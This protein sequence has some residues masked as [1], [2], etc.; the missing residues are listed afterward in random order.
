M[1]LAANAQCPTGSVTFTSQADVNNFIA[2]YPECTEIDGDVIIDGATITSLS[3]LINITSITGAV[4]IREVSGLQSLGG[5]DNLETVGTDFILR[6]VED[7][8]DISALS[9]LVSVGGELT[10]RSCPELEDLD[11]LESLTTVGLG[12]IVRDC[13]SLTG[14]EGLT[15]VTYVGEI[16][17]VVECPSLISLAG[18]ENIETIIGGEE[19]ALV[20]EGNDALTSLEGFGSA[21]TVMSG[22]I[23]ISANGHLSY[24]SVPAIC[25][26]LQNIPEGATATFGVNVTGC[27]TEAEVL[28]ECAP[29]AAPV[30]MAFTPDTGCVGSTVTITGTDFM[31]I[32][33]VTIGDEPVL[34]FTVVSPT[35]ITAVAGPNNVGVIEVTN[36]GGTA[37]TSESFT[38]NTEFPAAPVGEITQVISVT[39]PAMATLADLEA[40]PDDEGIIAWY[41]T[42]ED[43]L[44]WEN[45]LPLDTVLTNGETY[46]ATQS[47]GDCIGINTLAVTVDIVLGQN[48]FNS[49]GFSY[50]PVPVKDVLNLSYTSEITGVAVH[51]MIGQRVLSLK[52]TAT[53]IAVD[54]DALPYGIYSVTVNAKEGSKIIKVIKE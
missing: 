40:T 9:S 32:T 24:C 28:A 43:A 8:V 27:N 29:P 6:E 45:P 38:V 49:A 22:S 26:Y 41:A 30:I 44:A 2:T 33:V 35:E 3:G 46:Y 1:A 48:D 21:A 18:L 20:I 42:E 15:S 19:G 36:G 47:V 12:L 50:Y 23:T 11:G 7:L 52:T 51:N 4:E 10:F 14:I 37:V 13:E 39:D 53:N 31:G 16:L 54:M 5:L 34:S 25:N 17:E